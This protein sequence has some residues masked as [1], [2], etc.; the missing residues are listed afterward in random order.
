MPA[1]Q[2][3]PNAVQGQL[4]LQRRYHTTFSLCLF[5]A[6]ATQTAERNDLE[7]DEAEQAIAATLEACSRETELVWLLND[8]QFAVLLPHTPLAGAIAY[9]ER[10]CEVVEAKLQL[11]LN[12]GMT[13]VLDGDT[14]ESLLHRAD[15]ALFLAQAAGP[16]E[17]FQHTGIEVRPAQSRAAANASASV[18]HNER[19]DPPLNHTGTTGDSAALNPAI[20]REAAN[21]TASPAR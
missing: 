16:G 15:E 14:R 10:A 21:E 17:L 1:W 20:W 11:T 12:V 4:A 7:A 9:A 19:L 2:T 13:T 18:Q 8:S 3:L 6:S 5:Q